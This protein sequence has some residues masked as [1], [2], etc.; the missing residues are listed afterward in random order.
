[1]IEAKSTITIAALSDTHFSEETQPSKIDRTC[2]IPGTSKVRT[3]FI[4]SCA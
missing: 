4:W 2:H 1:M 3:S